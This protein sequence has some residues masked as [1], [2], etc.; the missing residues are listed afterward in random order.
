MSLGPGRV[1]R[2]DDWPSSHVRARAALSDRLDGVID[3]AEEAWLETHLAACPACP[4]IADEYAAQRAELRALRDRTP[5]PPRDLWA[6]TAAAIENESRFRANGSAWRGRRDRRSLLAPYAVLS[7]ALV[8]AVIAGTL[9][10]RPG[11]L[12]GEPTISPEIALGSSSEPGLPGSVNPASDAPDPTPIPVPGQFVAWIAQDPDGG[13]RIKTANVDE[14]C[15]PASAEPCD[16]A[17]PSSDSPIKLDQSPAS[18]FGS[19]DGDQL[20]VV[21]KPDGSDSGSVSVLPLASPTTGPDP[22]PSVE[23]TSSAAPSPAPPTPTPSPSEP[24][25][26]APPSP[27]ASSSPEVSPSLAPSPSVTV[28]PSSEPGGPIQIA[29]GV[30]L[31]GQ[32]AAYSPSGLWFAFT[33]RPVDGSTGPDIYAWKV[34][35]PLARAVTTDHRSVFG[36]W[37]G[38]IAVGSTVVSTAPSGGQTGTADLSGSSFLLDP[39]TAIITALPQTGHAWRPAV[40]PSGRQ[41]VYWAGNLRANETVPEYLP[42]NGRLVL[43]DWGTS[44]VAG[45]SAGASADPNGSPATTEPAGS[46]SPSPSSGDQTA[47]RHETTIAA[48]RLADWDARWDETGTRLAVWIADSQDPTVGWLSLYRVDPFDGR[49]DLR[50]PLLDAARA[51]AGYA[52]SE[53]SLVWAEP[54]RD[55]TASG[56]RIQVL[57]W[58]EDGSGTVETVPGPVIVIR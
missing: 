15:P 55:G 2:P 7:A 20:I 14:V 28:S 35:D 52:L 16:T 6:R 29:S 38:D 24:A 50:K 12:P 57:A 45:P 48:G 49:I 46:P 9:A 56:S 11:A 25:P 19:P 27:S 54:P 51:T 36:S 26:T 17:A 41:A 23:P 44:V 5:E 4:A 58:T 30:V 47:D 39:S 8:V 40:D 42:D 22:S 32:S 33:A 37:V 43:G 18:V 1:R 13:F 31:V 3:P 53:G 34:G 10:T 21:S